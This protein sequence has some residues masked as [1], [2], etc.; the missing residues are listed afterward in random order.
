MM[1]AQ[2]ETWFPDVSFSRVG[3]VVSDALL[4]AD[5]GELFLEKK[6]SDALSLDENVIKDASFSTTQGFGLRG[7][8]GEATLYA[9]SADISLDAMRHASSS[10]KSIPLAGAPLAMAPTKA[11]PPLPP[12]RPQGFED[13]VQ[14]LEAMNSY[15]RALDPRVIQVS[16]GVSD[17]HQRVAILKSQGD[18]AWDERTYAH[19]RISITVE[20]QGRRERGSVR[21]AF[22]TGTVPFFDP[23][24]WQAQVK[25]ALR[26]ALLSLE[27][28]PAPAGVMPVILGPGIPGVL[29]HE[30]V[31]HGFEGDFNR[32]GHSV[33][34]TQMGQSVAAPGVTVVDDGRLDLGLDHA[35]GSFAIDD[36]GTPTQETL[37]IHE[38]RMVGH[39]CDRLNGRLMGKGSTGNGRRQSYAHAPIPRM[40]NT[41]MRAGSHT[42]AEMISSVKRGIYA[43]DFGGGQVDI[44]SGNFVFSTTEAY[45]VE[46]GKI[47]APLKDATL[48]GNGPQAMKEITMI[49]ADLSL[50]PGLG[51][52]G[53]AG[54][55]VPVGL[56][57]PSL[58]IG[59][60]TVGGTS[61]S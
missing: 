20:H 53:K 8:F 55:S 41:F 54:Q 19:L 33:F 28:I 49:G 32:K 60:L 12:I 58:L 47:T 26:K 61:A 52:C 10:L 17:T 36:E 15:A 38:G 1:M 25:E 13:K 23:V 37:L 2:P 5:D 11:L 40:T 18:V 44:V 48:M 45:L 34:A 7:V 50:D 22:R 3:Q 56:G 6:T 30:A 59:S 4:R 14:L 43:C 29:L 51:M 42:L 31:G 24:F 46:D 21:P 35:H 27:A 9:H 16:L 39:L 57:Q